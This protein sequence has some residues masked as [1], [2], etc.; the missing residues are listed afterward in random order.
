MRGVSPLGAV[1]RKFMVL[2]LVTGCHAPEDVDVPEER[3]AD[4]PLLMWVYSCSCLG[5]GSSLRRN[6][7]C[8]GVRSKRRAASLMSLE[9]L[10][11]G[12]SARRAA[13]HR[14]A[15]R[16]GSP[17]GWISSCMAGVPG[18]RVAPGGPPL[19]NDSGGERRRQVRGGGGARRLGGRG[20]RCV[21]RPRIGVLV[22]GLVEGRRAGRVLPGLSPVQA[23]YK[24]D[25]RPVEGVAGEV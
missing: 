10:A 16:S 1:L 11:C 24:K 18:D 5:G 12:C 8:R 6:S 21:S 20:R 25:G 22:V 9:R 14:T 23:A 4:A 3:V 19:P 13:I 7:S 2:G 17:S 15:L